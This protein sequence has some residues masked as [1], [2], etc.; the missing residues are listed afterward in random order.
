VGQRRGLAIGRPAADGKPRYV[1]SISPV[2]RTVTVGPVERLS[3][4]RICC[5]TPTWCGAPPRSELVGLAQV[6][7]HAEPIECRAVVSDGR[8]EVEL[9]A[10]LAGVAAGQTLVLYDDDRVVGS[11]T[12]EAAR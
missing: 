2:D 3:V 1:L 8:L 7:A 5:G 6:R 12:I 9:T 10:P 11:A 4:T